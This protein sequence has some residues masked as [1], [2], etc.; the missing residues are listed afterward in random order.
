MG[1]L[2]GA[3]RG[4]EKTRAPPSIMINDDVMRT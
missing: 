1:T 4:K 3:G 2:M